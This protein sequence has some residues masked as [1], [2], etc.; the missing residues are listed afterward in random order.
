MSDRR[1]SQERERATEE[2]VNM[3]AKEEDLAAKEDNKRRKAKTL[4]KNKSWA[5]WRQTCG[6]VVH[7]PRPYRTQRR[8]KKWEGLKG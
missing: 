6:P 2:K 5:E 1:D 3:K 4:E 7:T 8:K